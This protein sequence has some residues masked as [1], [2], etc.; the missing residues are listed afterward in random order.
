MPATIHFDG[1]GQKPG[2]IVSSCVVTLSDGTE[3]EAV[4]HYAEGTH[5]IAEYQALILG[6]GIA[7]NHGERHVKATGDSQLVVNQV[8]GKS[9]TKH[10]GLIPLHARAKELLGQF[11]SW[12]VDW[13]GREENKRAD[14]LG[15]SS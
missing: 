7:L 10:P 2:P 13:V 6:L 11:D 4:E 12:S 5:N 1:G 14:K 9:R 3:K 15:R 8:N